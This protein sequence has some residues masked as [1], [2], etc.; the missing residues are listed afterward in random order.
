MCSLLESATATEGI[1]SERM[2]D[3][4]ACEQAGVLSFMELEVLTDLIS[5]RYY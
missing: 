2:L 4:A 3:S 1:F 5:A